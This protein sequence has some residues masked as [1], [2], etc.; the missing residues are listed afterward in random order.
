MRRISTT[1]RPGRQITVTEAEYL[2]LARQNLVHEEYELAEGRDPDPV[3]DGTPTG[4]PEG[5]HRDSPEQ[6]DAVL[7]PDKARNR[8]GRIPGEPVPP[9]NQKES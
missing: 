4:L 7:N 5:E 2:D 3:P 1:N 6:M 8:R 9:R